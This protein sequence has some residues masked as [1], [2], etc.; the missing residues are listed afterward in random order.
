[1]Q[2]NPDVMPRLRVHDIYAQA[3]RGGKAAAATPRWPAP[4]GGALVHPQHPAAL[5]HHPARGAAIVERQKNFFT[6]GELAMRPLVLRE[7]ADELGLHESTISRVTTA[8]YMATPRG[9]FELK[10]FFGSA[11]GTDAGGNASSTAVRALIKQFVAAE[12]PEAAVGQ[13]AGRDAEGAGHRVRA[14]HRGQIPRGAQDR[15]TPLRKPADFMA[16]IVF[17]LPAQF[18]TELQVYISHVNQGGHLDNAQLLSLVSEARLRFFH[19]L[20]YREA[21]W[22]GPPS[23]SATCWRSTSPRPSMARRCACRCSPWTSTATAL[24]WCFA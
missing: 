13:P 16:R 23:W 6:H 21:T 12:D 9:T 20:G 10:Y 7:I 14:P 15:P 1:V 4:A 19:A 3:L 24:T 17:D 22:T 8:K 18:S 2:L 11:L 5:R